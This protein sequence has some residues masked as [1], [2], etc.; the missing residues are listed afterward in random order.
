MTL[1]TTLNTTELLKQL[2]EIPGV[3][4]YERAI[5]ER[6]IEAMDPLVDEV[7]TDALG[8]VLARKQGSGTNAPGRIMLAAHMDEIGLMVTKLD[9]G[10]LRFSA[11]GGIDPSVLPSQEVVVHGRRDL[12]GLIASRPPHVLPAAERKKPI[13][14]DQ[15]FI[16]VGLTAEELAEQ[17]Q[18][19]DLVSIHQETVTLN[20]KYATGK[21]LDNRASVATVIQ[22]LRRLQSVQHTWDVYA[23]ATVQEE[24]GLRGAVTSTYGVN[25]TL[26]IALD[27][28]FAPQPGAS[29][30]ETVQWDKGPAIAL[31]PNIHPKLHERLLETA[32]AHEIPYS[33]E[34]L[35]GRTGTDAWA[36]QVTRA[37]IPTALLSIPIRNMH[38]PAETILLKDIERTARLLAAFI[39][40]LD[41]ETL[42]S[43]K[44]T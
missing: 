39:A 10:F 36:M 32:K 11:V 22:T 34:V 44:L 20:D 21:A 8:N 38:T 30:E 3:S 28:T 4:G 7:Y 41:E 15:L 35:P 33:V 18:V 43:L 9:Q 17:V 37:G 14:M 6:V 5:R 29:E 12:P 24:V 25:P 27:V 19:G 31:G 40:A 42:A 13:P 16:D 2:T 23:V 1:D 26:G